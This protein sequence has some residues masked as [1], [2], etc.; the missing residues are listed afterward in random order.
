MTFPNGSND[1]QSL[2][3]PNDERIVAVCDLLEHATGMD[4]EIGYLEDGQHND[5]YAIARFADTT[6]IIL[7]DQPEP[8]VAADEL[9]RS[10]LNNSIC[11]CGQTTTL[12]EDREGCYW[13]RDGTK[14]V[15]S[16]FGEGTG[17]I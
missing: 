2:H 16:C 17:G 11:R 8:G 5:W 10:L 4:V 1:D 13:H 12:D 3:D 14:W 15:G 9:A 6:Q 7:K